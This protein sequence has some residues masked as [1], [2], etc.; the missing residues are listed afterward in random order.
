[1]DRKIREDFGDR[2]VC[3]EEGRARKRRFWSRGEER[4]GKRVGD[5]VPMFDAR[6]SGDAEA[7]PAG[8]MRTVVLPG[9]E[10]GV[11]GWKRSW[12]RSDSASILS[13]VDRGSRT[14]DDR[15]SGGVVQWAKNFVWGDRHNRKII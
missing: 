2:A 9:E 8:E 15:P 1:M 7:W 14:S 11:R 5:E 3:G 6:A 4:N 12:S 10:V 13:R